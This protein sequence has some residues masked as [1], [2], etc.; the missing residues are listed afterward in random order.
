M[1][2]ASRGATMTNN[3]GREGGRSLESQENLAYALTAPNGG[4]RG[5]ER[6]IATGLGVRRL[7][8][9]ECERLQGWPDDHTRY[10]ADGS[11]IADGPRYRLIGNGVAA[12]CAAWIA[13]RLA[14]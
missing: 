12:P 2:Q 14:S 1:R 13:R 11:E 8:P 10:R 6:N 5:Q 7:T 9:R 3:R 4:G